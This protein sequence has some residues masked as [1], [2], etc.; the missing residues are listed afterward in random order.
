[1]VERKRDHLAKSL[2]GPT[3]H[4]LN[5]AIFRMGNI[6]SWCDCGVDTPY[7]HG[8]NMSDINE[9]QPRWIANI[10][11]RFEEGVRGILIGF[12]EISDL[13][14]I[15]EMGPHWDSIVDITIQ[16]LRDADET[17]TVEKGAEI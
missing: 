12:E 10:N 5:C 1:M 3:L 7:T 9:E 13:G 17:M 4:S 2:G 8:D 15:I 11:Y 6:R 14:Q 16:R